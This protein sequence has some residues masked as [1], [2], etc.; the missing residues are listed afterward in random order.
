MRVPL[1]QALKRRL[2]ATGQWR[3]ISL[4]AP[5]EV[6]EIKLAVGA[7][8][9][10]VT[11][12][13]AVAALAPF[14]IR[15]GFEGPFRSALQQ[16]AA[17]E[18]RFWERELGRVIGVLRLTPVRSW[19]SAGAE[20]GL[21]EV[22]GGGH[23]C[24]HRVRRAW[25]SWMYQ[26]AVRFTPPEKLL[27]APTAVEQML[28]FYL[29][30]RPV[31]FVSVD[32]GEHSNL[33]PMDLVGPLLPD[34]FTLALRNT[35]P[36]VETIKRARR[37]AL[38]DVPGEACQLAYQLGTHHKKR[39]VEWESLP[40]PVVRSREFSLRVPEMALRIREIEVLDFQAVGS[41]TLFVGHICSE[42]PLRSG[43][44]LFHTSGVHQRLRTRHQ[45]P[46]AEAF[47]EAPA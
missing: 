6:V 40:F 5:Q 37:V 19:S 27:M 14:T 22:S 13:C 17:P 41:H 38:G 20:L 25:D 26:R 16:A 24:A 34:R 31:F 21:F 7:R 11:G 10:D 30:P 35:S 23:Y 32:D 12:N 28:T 33:F 47:S 8:E 15:L 39:Q 1:P 3:A 36:S 42:Q 2:R 46:F 45:R 9:Y 4:P 44:Q 29:C 43:P 18:L